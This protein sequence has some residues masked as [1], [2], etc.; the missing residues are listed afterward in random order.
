MALGSQSINDNFQ[1]D[2]FDTDDTLT[3]ATTLGQSVSGSNGNEMVLHTPQ[4]TKTWTIQSDVKLV[5]C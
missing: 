1:T 3:S 4:S 2:L 5:S